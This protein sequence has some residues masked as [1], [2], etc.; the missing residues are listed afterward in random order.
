MDMTHKAHW[1][2]FIESAVSG[3]GVVR[4]QRVTRDID[5]L[6]GPDMREFGPQFDV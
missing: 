1:A 5:A 6:Y 2:V 3:R 4:W